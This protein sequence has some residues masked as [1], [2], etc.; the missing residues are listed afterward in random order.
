MLCRDTLP[1]EA[2]A[3]LGAL[4]RPA[5]ASFAADAPQ[6]CSVSR[7]G[8]GVTG[9]PC[10]STVGGAFAPWALALLHAG[11]LDANFVQVGQV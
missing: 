9:W 6:V 8:N 7:G 3:G 1:L 4:G 10:A 5:Q 11:P 2:S